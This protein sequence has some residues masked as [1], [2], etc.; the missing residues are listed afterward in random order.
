[1]V[2]CDSITAKSVNGDIVIEKC[3]TKKAI[4][5]SSQNGDVIK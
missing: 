3:K 2:T 5:A 1:M 4:K